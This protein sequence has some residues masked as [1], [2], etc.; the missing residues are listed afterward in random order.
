MIA[1]WILSVTYS[2][3]NAK[4][5][6]SGAKFSKPPPPEIS[7]GQMKLFSF[8]GEYSTATNKRESTSTSKNIA[9]FV[10][11]SRWYPFGS[12]KALIWLSLRRAV[13]HS[14][15]KFDLFSKCPDRLRASISIASVATSTSLTSLYNMP[16]DGSE[17][18]RSSSS[19]SVLSIVWSIF[20]VINSFDVNA[21]YWSNDSSLRCKCISS[22]RLFKAS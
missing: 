13:S 12:N 9:R 19:K 2:K 20:S 3:R 15:Q 8:R 5:S 4:G 16:R 17:V 1:S 21:W 11:A 14:F 22:K 18:S 10:N 6:R 7:P